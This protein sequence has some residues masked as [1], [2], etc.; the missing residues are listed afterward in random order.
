MA[1]TTL[2]GAALSLP[3]PNRTGVTA[4]SP[5]GPALTSA[6]PT[7][8]SCHVPYLPSGVAGRLSCPLCGRHSGP[9]PS[10]SRSGAAASNAPRAAASTNAHEEIV[11]NWMIGKP[12]PCPHCRSPLHRFDATVL[13]CH[14]CG[15][16]LELP[17]MDGTAPGGAVLRAPQPG[18]GEGAV[19]DCGDH[20][21]H[22]GSQRPV[23]AEGRNAGA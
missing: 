8:P 9:V 11:A 6:S 1:T 21:V 17:E 15:R 22:V 19:A 14:S 18:S 7:C 16:R 10:L 5:N 2:G 4:G 12:V 13:I 23:G 20:S 3:S